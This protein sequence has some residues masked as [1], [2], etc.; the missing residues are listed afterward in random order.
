MT[1][2]L[3][4]LLVL[5]AFGVAAGTSIP[6]VLCAIHAGIMHSRRTGRPIMAGPIRRRAAAW[7]QRR[8][9]RRWLSGWPGP[10]RSPAA[11][12]APRFPVGADVPPRSAPAGPPPRVRVVGS[13][14]LTR[15]ARLFPAGTADTDPRPAVVAGPW[16]ST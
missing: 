9:I 12:P 8:A 16:R 10:C 6:W 15:A 1:A 2:Q 3:T 4:P 11:A 5:Q 13:S 7:I 14:S